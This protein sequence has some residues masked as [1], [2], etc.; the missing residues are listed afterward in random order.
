MT[1]TR[2]R[3]AAVVGAVI[4]LGLGASAVSA[5]GSGGATMGADPMLGE[6]VLVALDFAPTGYMDADGALLPI[7]QNQALFSLYGTVHGGDGRSTF[8]LPKM[9]PPIA[10]L[11]Y[12]VAVQGAFPQRP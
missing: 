2:A 9:D 1:R 3:I 11:K 7:G 4:V 8:G 5:R 12:I 10:G 6:I